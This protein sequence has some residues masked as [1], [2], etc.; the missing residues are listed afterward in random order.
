[1]SVSPTILQQAEKSFQLPKVLVGTVALLIFLYLLTLFLRCNHDNTNVICKLSV[2]IR[3]V[4]LFF[5]LLVAVLQLTAQY[6]FYNMKTIGSEKQPPSTKTSIK[7]EATLTKQL[8]R[9]KLVQKVADYVSVPF[10]VLIVLAIASLMNSN[11]S[12][13]IKQTCSLCGIN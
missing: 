6:Q 7:D 1:M 10:Y 5:V 13:C 4:L 12:L 11:V 8:V 3:I 9:T 2:N